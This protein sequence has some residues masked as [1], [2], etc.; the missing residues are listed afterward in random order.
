VV[1]S[2]IIRVHELEHFVGVDTDGDGAPDDVKVEFS[3]PVL[4]CP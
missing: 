2:Q 4:S 3:R 1:G